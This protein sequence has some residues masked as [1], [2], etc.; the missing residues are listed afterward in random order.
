MNKY[1]SMLRRILRYHSGLEIVYR[2][3]RG[4][5]GY[6][7]CSCCI[8][9]T[10]GPFIRRFRGEKLVCLRCG[11]IGRQRAVVKTLKEHDPDWR[12]MAIHE[13]SPSISSIRMFGKSCKGYVPTFYW[14]D[15]SVGDWRDGFRCEDLSH[16]TFDDCSFDLVLTQDVFEHIPDPR[17]AFMEVA[18][19]LKPG[20]AHIFT[21]PIY[22][23]RSVT[24]TRYVGSKA[25]HVLEPRFHGN[26][27]DPKGSL[28]I[29]D[30]GT[31]IVEVIKETSGLPTR[32]LRI[33]DEDAGIEGR[34]YS[35][36]HSELFITTKPK[37]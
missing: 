21:V 20:G 18:R 36:T 7:V 15:V 33:R 37:D 12:Q 3:I 29:T 8:C 16:Q 4:R 30:W 23:E 31:D 25:L 28:V 26:P 9:G 14:P 22:G 6:R 2:L 17:R 27:I 1:K 5:G 10:T 34:D 13:S 35:Q 11:S 32:Y 24:R 19:T